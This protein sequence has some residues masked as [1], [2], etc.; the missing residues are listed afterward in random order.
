MF[1]TITNNDTRKI[2]RIRSNVSEPNT[3]TN[4][5]KTEDNETWHRNLHKI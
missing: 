3:I 2:T 5:N 4:K 1:A